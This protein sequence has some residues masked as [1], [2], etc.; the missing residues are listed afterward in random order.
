GIATDAAGNAYV[1]GKTKSVDFPGV[2]AYQHSSRGGWDIVVAKLTPAGELVFSTYIGG[3]NDDEG[4]KIAVNASS[5]VFITGSTFYDDFPLKIWLGWSHFG[6]K[7]DATGQ[8][9]SWFT[10]IYGTPQVIAL[11]TFSNLH[12]AG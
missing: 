10:P 3:S 6:L 7:L 2:N 9:I 1:I 8:S 11:D 4:G 12:V 5:E